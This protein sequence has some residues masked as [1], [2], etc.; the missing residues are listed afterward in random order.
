MS[1]VFSNKVKNGQRTRYFYYRC[2][3][4][5]KRDISFCG[6]RQVSSDRLDSY[7]I[8][9]LDKIANNK[10]YLDSLIFTLNYQQQGCQEGIE[11]K[12]VASLYTADRTRQI[13]QTLVNA[14]KLKSKAEKEIIIKKHIKNIIYSKEAIEVNLNYSENGAEKLT[15]ET[16]SAALFWAA[17]KKRRRQPPLNKKTADFLNST[18]RLEKL[19][20]PRGIEPRFSA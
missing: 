7:V 14:S 8:D 12:G 20:A 16:M 9:G 5:T 15:D 3:C 18:V 11:P 17:A 13:L 6:T 10:Q 2:S 4:V 19:V 1:A